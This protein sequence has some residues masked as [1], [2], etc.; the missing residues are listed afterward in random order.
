[1]RQILLLL[2]GEICPPCLI[3]FFKLWQAWAIAGVQ[4][5]LENNFLFIFEIIP[6]S[7]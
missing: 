6:A 7:L 1:M 5:H 4:E 3:Y 2:L